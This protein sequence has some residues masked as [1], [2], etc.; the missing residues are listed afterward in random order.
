MLTTIGL[1]GLASLLSAQPDSSTLP[2][3]GPLTGLPSPPGRHV[4]K[5]KALAN[6]SW[7]E[8][9]APAADPRWGRARGRSW[10]AKMP[11]AP[12]LR[13][14]F[15]FGEGIH[16]YTK[17]DGH[18]MDDLWFYDL[19]GHRWIC[20]YPGADTRTLD[21]KINASGFEA[22]ADS[23]PIPVASMG[24]GYEMTTY[25]TDR[26]RFLSMPNPHGYEKKSLPQRARWWQEPPRDASPWFF[27]T[28]TGK[29]NRLRT[30]T[31]GPV[32]SFGDVFLY[33]PERQQAFFAHRYSEVWFYD[34]R[35]NRWQQASPK[36]PK[37]PFGIDATACY[38]SRR[39]RIYM[40]G[41]SYPVAP[42][43]SNALWIYDLKSDTWIDPR[44]KGSPCKGS[45]SYPTK[46]A[47]MLYDSVNDVVLLVVASYFDSE[48]ERT[49]VYV[50]DPAANAWSAEARPIPE[51][52]SGNHKPKNGFYD[53]TLNAVILH[54]AG[55]SQD[56]GVM[57]AYRHRAR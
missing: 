9:G 27:E 31:T 5:I 43:R 42:L 23:T 26:K 19:N 25:D 24:H 45:T 20:C 28:A 32:S 54:T 16:G 22:T 1:I 37:P 17:P 7:I 40:G 48:K 47:V 14:A 30:G 21:L 44:P 51:K 39:Q 56:D 55:D 50:Y 10:L 3:S 12:E 38:D 29:W 8:L 18:Y 13:G 57:W 52:L 15:L 53:P 2:R 36:G 49:G 34:A 6:N 4:A 46:N 41:G 33:L 11:L 35:A